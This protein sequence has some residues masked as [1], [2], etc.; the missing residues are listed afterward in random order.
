MDHSFTYLRFCTTPSYFDYI[1][2][3]KIQEAL[4]SISRAG[5]Q[6]LPLNLLLLPQKWFEMSPKPVKRVDPLAV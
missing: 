4:P 5:R 3:L 2:R 6:A 1:T